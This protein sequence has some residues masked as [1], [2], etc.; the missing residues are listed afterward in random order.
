MMTLLAV[1]ILLAAFLIVALPGILALF[2]PKAAIVAAPF[3]LALLTAIAAHYVGFSFGGTIPAPPKAGAGPT[4]LCE[5]AI[6]QSEQG[7]LI[8]NRSNPLRVVVRH[9]LWA[10]LPQQAK[11]GLIT[12]LQMAR[13]TQA[14]DAPVEVVETPPR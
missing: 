3:Y 8:V 11:D 9:E 13:P 12:C 5:Q 6:A 10:E 2:R 7:G 14:R 1:A 4:G